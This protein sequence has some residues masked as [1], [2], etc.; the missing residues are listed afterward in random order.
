M[1]C[2]GCASDRPVDILTWIIPDKCGQCQTS[3][4]LQDKKQ[5]DKYKELYDL[6]TKKGGTDMPDASFDYM[7]VWGLAEMHGVFGST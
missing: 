4:D 7:C 3:S 2:P 1:Q 5:V 6:L